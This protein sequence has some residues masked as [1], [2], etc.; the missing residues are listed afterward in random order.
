[1]LWPR[2]E[3][4]GSCTRLRLPLLEIL[5]AATL[6]LPVLASAEEGASVFMIMVDGAAYEQVKSLYDR[7]KLPHL[8]DVV[9][10][11]HGKLLRSITTFPSSTAPSVPELLVGRYVDR[12][13]PDLLR[14]VQDFDRT[15][16]IL[17]RNEFQRSAWNTTDTDLFD[18]V[19]QTGRRSFSY[20]EGAF[21]WASENEFNALAYRVNYAAAYSGMP[22]LYDRQVMDNVLQDLRKEHP[23]PALLFI[24]LGAV[25]IVGHIRGP[26]HADYAKALLDTDAL[27]GRLLA[28]LRATEHPKGGSVFDHS[29]FFVF[30]D[31]G[32][33]P[34][35]H[36]VNLGQELNR[37]GIRTA[38]GSDLGAM[39]QA[40]LSKGWHKNY[41]AV[42]LGV[43]SNVADLQFRSR[44]SG[45]KPRPW[46]VRPALGEL[47]AMPV[48][49][50][51]GT[52]DLVSF[53]LGQ[54]G[55]EH[56]LLP[57]APGRVR[58]FSAGGGE[59]ELTAASEPGARRVAYRVLRT[60][61][62]GRDPLG[63]LNECE[64]KELVTP[65][66]EDELRYFDDHRWFE[67][68]RGSEFA[69]APPL[70]TRAFPAGPTTPDIVVTARKNFG[71]MPVVRGDHG[72]LRRSSS[73]SFLIAAGP[74]L[75]AAPALDTVRLIDVNL[76]VRRLL[77][78]PEDPLTDSWGLT[79]AQPSA[80]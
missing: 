78:L 54:V 42:V 22:G 32:M 4:A 15:T 23:P 34:T 1:M 64:A 60:D 39:M 14:S 26:D 62:G 65:P 13:R 33:E 56:V 5:L 59:A 61:A 2:P 43:G 69:F 9:R 30:G 35:R 37:I 20:F 10:S 72:G 12:C 66:G 57:L 55:V 17:A 38:D 71:F 75:L 19:S 21:R 48:T 45:G 53:L 52:V 74:D 36:H 47:R 70:L 80:P 29:H 41:D 6:L 31:H 28:V 46:S 3:I 63:Y 50:G 8:R 51:E 44:S 11:K 49:R 79:P 40:S 18:L 77:G 7:G 76:E 58:I 27:I 73:R 16:G 67:V 25:D 68:T 24:G